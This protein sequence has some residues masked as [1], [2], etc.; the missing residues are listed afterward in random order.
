MYKMLVGRED[1]RSANVAEIALPET[2]LKHYVITRGSR[3]SVSFRA[4]GTRLDADGSTLAWRTSSYLSGTF[5]DIFLTK[6]KGC[7]IKELYERH[8]LYDIEEKII[9]YVKRNEGVQQRMATALSE[10][11]PECD[12]RDSICKVDETRLCICPKMYV[13]D[14]VSRTRIHQCVLLGYYAMTGR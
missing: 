13:C 5:A 7:D 2:Y 14:P 6:V 3:L 4:R 9:P 10:F 11:P 8:K 1:E 12:E